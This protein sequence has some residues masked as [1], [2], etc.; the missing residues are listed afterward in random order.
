MWSG[1][2]GLEDKGKP[3]T[4]IDM[5]DDTLAR[6]RRH[7]THVGVVSRDI[8]QTRVL[9]LRPDIDRVDH[10]AH[11]SQDRIDRTQH[12]HHIDPH[13]CTFMHIHGWLREH[14]LE[15]LS[16]LLAPEAMDPS[17][18]PSHVNL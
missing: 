9:T 13:S 2:E 14:P 3:G 4:G 7:R 16:H 15:T 8:P 10:I 12:T 1:A 5:D 6:G 18:H 11:R 17:S